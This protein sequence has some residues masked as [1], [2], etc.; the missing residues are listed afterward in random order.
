MQDPTPGEPGTTGA[1]TGRRQ[2]AVL[3]GG[4]FWC[5]EAVLERLRGVRSVEPGYAGGHVQVCAKKTGHAEVV[6]VVFDPS[7]ISYR[8]L[9]VVFFATHDPTTRNRQGSDVGPQ[10]RSIVLY[11]SDDQE[12]TARELIAELERE[13]VFESPIVTEVVPLDVFWPA[14]EWHRDYFRRNPYQPY[15]SVVIA[16]KVAKLRAGFADRLRSEV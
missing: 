3:G 9:L 7:E 2:T 10:Y 6:R 16:P 4:C 12:R 13:D 11:G 14:E 5:T 8:E 15:C 1:E